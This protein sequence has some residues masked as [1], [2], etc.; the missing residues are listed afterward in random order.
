MY[1]L[2]GWLTLQGFQW[3]YGMNF[4][5]RLAQKAAEFDPGGYRKQRKIERKATEVRRVPVSTADTFPVEKEPSF[6]PRFG[7]CL[8]WFIHMS[9]ATKSTTTATATATT[10]PVQPP[11]NH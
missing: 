2:V 11:L 5:E 3:P 8:L 10:T 1:Q 7:T 9:A 4:R 6:L